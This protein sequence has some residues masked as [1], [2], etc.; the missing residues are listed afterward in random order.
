MNCS[1]STKAPFRD[2]TLCSIG[3]GVPSNDCAT[4]VK[5]ANDKGSAIARRLGTLLGPAR[6]DIAVKSHVVAGGSGGGG[7]GSLQGGMKVIFRFPRSRL[8]RRAVTGSVTFKPV[9]FNIDRRSTVTV[10]GHMLPLINLSRSFVSHSPFSL[11]KNRVE[12]MTVTNMLTVRPRILIL[13]RPATKLSPTNEQ[14]VVGVF[15]RLRVS[16]NLAVMLI[17]RRVGSI[18]ACTSRIIVLRGKAI[19]GVKRPSRVFRSTR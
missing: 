11:S 14:R 16:G 10:I 19:I 7:L 5:R 6:N 13:S 3:L 18:T 2:Q 8:F 4:L 9:G 15:G 17:A 12:H 1:C